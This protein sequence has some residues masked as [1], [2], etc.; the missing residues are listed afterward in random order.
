MSHNRCDIAAARSLELTAEY[1]GTVLNSILFYRGVYPPS[2]F[3]HVPCRLVKPDTTSRH[4]KQP[5]TP[6]LNNEAGRSYMRDV[7]GDILDLLSASQLGSVVLEVLDENGDSV[8]NWCIDI[9]TDEDELRRAEARGKAYSFKSGESTIE[10]CQGSLQQLMETVTYLPPDPTVCT[11]RVFIR[12]VGSPN[13]PWS[14]ERSPLSDGSK[15][16]RLRSV[17]TSFTTIGVALAI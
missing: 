16:V 3:A 14:T 7:L 17:S 12:A 4:R 6:V 9:T 2:Y 13:G 8:E 5:T 1:V 11:F 15:E 10:E